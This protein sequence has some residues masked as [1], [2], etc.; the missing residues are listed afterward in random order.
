[1]KKLRVKINCDCSGPKKEF[2][3]DF[4]LAYGNGDTHFI[5]ES[6][7][8][9][10]I[11]EIF[12]DRTISGKEEF[13]S[14]TKEMT[15]SETYEMEIHSIITHGKEAAVRGEMTMNDKTYAFCDIYEFTSAGGSTISKMFTFVVE[16]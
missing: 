5:T 10:I 6:V 3:R 7:S 4:N 1:M 16:V 15:K 9:D 2:L 13:T 12:G 11:W 8:D 14:A